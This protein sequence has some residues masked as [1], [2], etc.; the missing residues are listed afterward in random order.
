MR[1][2]EQIRL[3]ESENLG[4]NEFVRIDSVTKKHR[5]EDVMRNVGEREKVS[6]GFYLLDPKKV[7]LMKCIKEEELTESVYKY[8]VES[9]MG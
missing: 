7:R 5:S 3:Q 4:S 9:E 8:E 6:D 1:S 2:Q